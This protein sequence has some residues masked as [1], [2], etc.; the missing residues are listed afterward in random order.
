MAVKIIHL[1]AAPQRSNSGYFGIKL[2]TPDME[3]AERILTQ[4]FP[5]QFNGWEPIGARIYTYRGGRFMVYP[6]LFSKKPRRLMRW[7]M[8]HGMFWSGGG[9]WTCQAGL[10][11]A[12]MGTSAG[13]RNRAVLRCKEW[14]DAQLAE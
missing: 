1:D 3:A 8:D 10:G 14:I 5:D 4:D 12:M 6:G 11:G 7:L 2:G 13:T 9:C